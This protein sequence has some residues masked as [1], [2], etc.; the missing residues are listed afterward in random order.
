MSP[1]R[2]L[3]QH[4]SSE[5]R[6]LA[7]AGLM[8]AIASL[9]AVAL[10]GV[11]GWLISRAAEMPPVLTLTVAAALVRGLAISR[12]LFR[13]V[14]RL[15]GHDAAFRGLTELRVTVYSTL[16][17]LAPTGLSVFGRGDLLS[18]LVA[19]VDAALDLPLRVILPWL[20]AVLVAVATSAF[21]LWL[22]PPTGAVVALL[23]LVAIA[24]VLWVVARLARHAEAQMAP[25]RAELSA[26]VVRTL[27]ATPEL[28]A[29]GA[30]PAAAAR[31]SVVDDD[32]TRLNVRE[33]YALG[34]GGGVGV[35][36]QG[37]GVCLALTAAIPAV[38][39][40]TL[41][42]V[43]LAVAALLPL[44]LFDVLAG[45]PSSALAF[46]RL[47]GSAVRLQQVDEA[48]VP[49]RDP[50]E[51]EQLPETFTGLSLRAVTARWTQAR[52]AIEDIDLD[53]SPGDRVAVVGPS[54]AGKS[55]L[56][57]V[58]LDFLPYEGSVRMSGV[59][60]EDA[61]GDDVRR[62]VGLL[63]QQAHIFDTTIADNVRIGDPA[64][65]DEQVAAALAAAQLSDWVDSL[66]EGTSTRVGSFGLAVSGGERQRIALARLLLARRPFVILDEPTEHL[67]GPTADALTQ[68]L[69]HA[70]AD[71]TQLVITHRLLG[72][73]GFDRIV[74]L[75]QGRIVAT[76]THDELMAH[77]GWY[78][79]QWRLESERRDMS[80][81]LA[82]LPVGR[83]VAGPA[84]T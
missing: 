13:Y 65:S 78:A 26:G 44:A 21:L 8:G 69:A 58:I 53:V 31:L 30:G 59:E 74:V 2:L 32:L 63:T 42:P 33:S 10:L 64:A 14:E 15:V 77:G 76:G 51:A 80:A 60:V 5:R 72:L 7:L 71:T 34:V 62:L 6:R 84:A 45:L 3:W 54:G 43:W 39:A 56:A 19:D 18:R 81:L 20:Q 12:G 48:P 66:P 40:G 50:A 36:V 67:D 1:I 83:G 28:T 9:S 37:A 46:Q 70:L 79:Q 24:A 35:L 82:G 11:S 23:S 61:D 27:D 29:F 68:T 16:E 25:T 4:M 55:T 73:E 17:R 47:R 41:D 38:V 49:V 22:L 52:A 75:D 57:N